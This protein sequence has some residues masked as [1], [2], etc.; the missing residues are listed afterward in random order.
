[1]S[2]EEGKTVDGRYTLVR[3]IGSG[4][5]ADVWL[6]RDTELGRDVAL[7]VLHQNFARDEEFVNRFRLEASAAAG[8]QHPNVV[9]VYDRG[10]FEDTYY[11]A[12]EYVEGSPLRDL[13]SR[14][15][16][17]SEAIEVTRQVLAAAGFAHDRGFVH[18]DLKPMNV[19]IDRSGR[20][21]VTDFG[22]ARADNSEITRTGSVLGTAQYLSPEQAQGF[23]VTRASDLY[24]IGVILFEMLTGRVPFD[25]D[26]AVAIAMKQVS[27]KPPAPSSLNPAVTP[28]LESVVLRALAKDPTN[29]YSSAEEMLTALD[30][31]EANPHMS[32]H[33]ERYD[34]FV[35][36]P[37]E[38]DSNWKV[39]AIAAAVV[40][41]VAF[42]V[43]FF[44]LRGD[45][46]VRVPGVKG[47]S[48]TAA[49]L[50]LQAAGFEVDVDRV[51]SGVVEGTVIEQDPRGGELA[52]EGSTVTLSV[53]LGPAPAKIP[54]VIGKTEAQA[55]KKLEE[56]GFEVS[57]DEAPSDEVDAG[58]VIE[59]SPSVGFE[60]SVGQTVTIVVSTGTDLVLI[61]SVVGLDRIDATNQL[62]QAKFIVDAD[63][64]ESDAPEGQ[65]ISQSPT[66]EAEEGSRVRIVYSLGPGNVTLPSFVGE[67]QESAEKQI[68]KL[69]LNVSVQTE[70]TD[71]PNE[72][73]RVIAQSPSGGSVAPDSTVTITVGNYVE[74]IDPE[75]P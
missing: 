8:L 75:V 43:W 48:E 30:A 69:G 56:A 12:M 23:A 22:I 25:G 18:R 27:E 4:G 49:T 59:T 5:M 2:L 57:V 50:T 29:R 58:R 24:S 51:E 31:A 6:A 10:S 36:P 3:R 73:G 38:K 26:N 67:K 44:L 35:P 52:E 11:I 13:I 63:G 21:R 17:V 64:Q 16:S 60:G 37:E 68:E 53:S 45:D 32:G 14:G 74:P 41:L 70:D 15:L 71:D 19:L 66:G 39:W 34:A 62:E 28:A 54:D 20:V 47:D 7:K 72:D 65:V 55:T 46:G 1:M 40:A 33:T 42:L 61:P 9:A